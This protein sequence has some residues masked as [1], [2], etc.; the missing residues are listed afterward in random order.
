MSQESVQDSKSSIFTWVVFKL[1]PDQLESLVR[2]TSA[3]VLEM[4]AIHLL[5]LLLLFEIQLKH[6]A[7]VIWNGGPTFVNFPH[8]LNNWILAQKFEILVVL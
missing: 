1:M 6:V 5:L 7:D 3:D 4:V 8:F 2:K